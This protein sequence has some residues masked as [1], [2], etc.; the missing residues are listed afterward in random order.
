MEKQRRVP[1]LLRY[2]SLPITFKALCQVADI[3]SDLTK[4]LCSRL[5]FTEASNQTSGK[6]V[7][8]ETPL[9]IC[10]GTWT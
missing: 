2:M 5:I 1:H 4:F 9:Y 6:A 8:W 3:L 10:T 7:Q